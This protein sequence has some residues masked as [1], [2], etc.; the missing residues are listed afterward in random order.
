MHHVTG[1][2]AASVLAVA[3]SAVSSAASAAPLFVAYD[4]FN[5]SGTVTRYATQAD[6]ANGTN[7]LSVTAISTATNDTRQTLPNARDGNVYVASGATGY[8][9]NNLA[10]FSTAWYFTT[11]PANGNGWGNPNNSNN[12]FVQYYDSSGN[13][14]VSGGWSNNYKTFSL[15][16]SGGDGDSFNFARLWAAPQAGGPSGD[17][18]GVFRSFELSFTA[19]FAVAAALNGATGWY[20]TS[21]MPSAFAG[22]AKGI[23]ENQSASNPAL[24]GFYAFDFAFDEGSWASN[25]GATWSDGGLND[26][27]ASAL[28]AAPA[29]VPE[30]VSLALIGLGLAGIAASRRRKVS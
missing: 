1:F 2:R 22:S 30:P 17:T 24:N 7:A 29:S 4:D 5:Y 19:D 15:G 20:D 28:F 8:D 23:F 12:G 3:L 10:Y 13:P 11:F 14:S 9:P 26:Y 6:A 21:D 27:G 18:S 25:V 16:V